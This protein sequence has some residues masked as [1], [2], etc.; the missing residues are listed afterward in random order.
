MG[1]RSVE[2]LVER[3]HPGR[4]QLDLGTGEWTV[5]PDHVLE[6]GGRTGVHGDDHSKEGPHAF[7]HQAQCPGHV[8][9]VPVDDLDRDPGADVAHAVRALTGRFA[10]FRFGQGLVFDPQ[11]FAEGV[12]GDRGD[13]NRGEFDVRCVAKLGDRGFGPVAVE[14]SRIGADLP[15][16]LDGLSGQGRARLA[17]V[18]APGSFVALDALG[19]S[20]SGDGHPLRSRPPCA[21]A[22]YVGPR[23]AQRRRQVLADGNGKTASVKPRRVEAHG[24]LSSPVSSR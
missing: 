3:R 21:G 10:G 12:G 7:R 24:L 9:P 2:T 20:Q 8:R 15:R 23:P 14:M 5:V 11:R 17:A 13:D 22:A 4:D 6:I 16:R 18:P 19:A 1:R